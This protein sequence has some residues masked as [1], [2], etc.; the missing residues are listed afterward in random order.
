MNDTIGKYFSD[1]ISDTIGNILVW[2]LVHVDSKQD[3]NF[4]FMHE[5]S[6]IVGKYFNNIISDNIGNILVIKHGLRHEHL[7]RH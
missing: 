7:T 2:V 4:V 5:I 3:S 1:I 6:I